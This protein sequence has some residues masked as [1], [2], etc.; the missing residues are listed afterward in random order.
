MSRTTVITCGTSILRN[1]IKDKPEEEFKALNLFL[2]RT[3]NVRRK[4]CAREEE[5]TFLEI[6]RHVQDRLADSD[7]KQSRN[8]SAEPNGL[9]GYYRRK[10]KAGKDIM[11]DMPQDVYYFIHTDTYQGEIAAELLEGW[12][13][14]QKG[15]RIVSLHKIQDL[16]TASAEEFRAGI[17]GLIQWCRAHLPEKH[18]EYNPVI[19]NLVGGFKVL[20]GY[21][22][23]LGM[24]YAYEIVYIFEGSG[25]LLTI[26]RLPVDFNASAKQAVQENAVAFRKMSLEISVSHDECKNANIPSSLLFVVDDVCL[27]FN[28]GELIW[29]EMKD[30]IYGEA[31]LESPAPNLI[32]YGNR[33]ESEVEKLERDRVR[34]VNQQ[35]DALFRYLTGGRKDNLNSLDYKKLEVPSGKLDFQFKL[36]DD[37]KA[38]RALC[39]DDGK[40]V[41][42]DHM[43]HL[44]KEKR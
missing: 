21:M 36:W 7:E 18:S 44:W 41:T 11:G 31:L 6:K 43:D 5:N 2:N 38:M 10:D 4:D 13:R 8:L 34:E 40:R 32:A 20:Q 33:F 9:I 42:I 14:G 22:Q 17:N 1:G 39:C 29:N 19:F 3:A 23:A 27:L 16:N 25:E 15:I 26:P 30:K 24:F 35:V 28:W 37:G 12:C